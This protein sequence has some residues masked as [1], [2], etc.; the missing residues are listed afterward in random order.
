LPFLKEERTV[1]HSGLWILVALAAGCGGEAPEQTDTGEKEGCGTPSLH[2]VSVVYLVVD[3]SGNGVSNLEVRLEERAWEPGVLGAGE[4][5][6]NGNG[7]L[8]AES[9]TDLP[10]CWGTMLN[11][12][13]VASDPSGYYGDAEKPVN[14]YLFGA[15]SDGS[16]R[17]DLTAFPIEIT[18]Q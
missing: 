18:P 8:L 1:K 14:S 17:A 5:D 4:T 6:G 12:V 10:G 13:V 3:S 11:Y 2:T 9:V 7:E 16:N 15:I